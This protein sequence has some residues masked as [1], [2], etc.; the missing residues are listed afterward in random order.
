LDAAAS[1]PPAYDGWDLDEDLRHVERLLRSDQAGAQAAKD[2]SAKQFR[3]DGPHAGPGGPHG[4]P[5]R[6]SRPK[7][8]PVGALAPRQG[9]ALSALAWI[10]LSLGTMGFVC[11]GVLLGWSLAMGRPELWNIGLPAA[12]GGQIVLLIGL[13]V[14]LDRLWHDSRKAAAKLDTVDEQIHALKTATTLLGTTHGPSGAFYAH[15]A[16]GAGPQLLLSDLK[17]Q[18]D[19]LAIKLGQD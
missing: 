9:S 4:S 16:D 3:L 10:A 5:I 15:W 11:G 13:I 12:L 19:L 17:S 18:L 1:A 14:Q 2:P 7:E 8:R 6:K